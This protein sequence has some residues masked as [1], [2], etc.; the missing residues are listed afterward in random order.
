MSGRGLPP[1][2]G[3]GSRRVPEAVY[4]WTPE[5]VE[6]YIVGVAAATSAR[7][8][9]LEPHT[10]RWTGARMFRLVIDPSSTLRIREDAIAAYLNAHRLWPAEIRD[11]LRADA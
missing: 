9:Y 5:L 3:L 4:R 1:R 6:R 8:P 2:R 10:T 7:V 11:Q